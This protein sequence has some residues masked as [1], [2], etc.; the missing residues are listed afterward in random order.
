MTHAYTQLF[1]LIIN[2][3]THTYTYHTQVIDLRPLRLRERFNPARLKREVDIMRRLSHPN[4][5]R[6]V[7][8]WRV[9]VMVYDFVLA[10]TYYS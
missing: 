8:V 5:I 7:E 10:A 4:I 3:S 9:W 2:E 6:F 1:F